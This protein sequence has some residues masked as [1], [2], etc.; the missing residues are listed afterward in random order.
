VQSIANNAITAASINAAALNGKGDWNIGKTG[1]ALSAA[2]VQA[3]WDALTSA[4][5]TV[6]SIGKRIAD[7]L[8]GDAYVRLHSDAAGLRPA[9]A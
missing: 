6:G 4:L 9:R 7:F 1:Y 3:I 8:T 2:G 5:T